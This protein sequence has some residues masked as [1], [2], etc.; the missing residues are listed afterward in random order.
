MYIFQFFKR[1]VRKANIPTWIYLILNILIIGAMVQLFFGD[2]ND[3][4]FYQSL[5]IGFLIY[6]L[7]IGISIS[8]LGEWV[9]RCQYGCK[10]IRETDNLSEVLAIFTEVYEKARKEDP[11]LCK[12]I[13]LYISE[14]NSPNAFALGRRTVCIT[15]GLLNLPINEIRAVLGHEFGHLA[16]KDTD[17]LLVISVGNLI[18]SGCMVLI[19][20]TIQ[21]FH[22][23]IE[24]IALVMGRTGGALLSLFNYLYHLALSVFVHGFTM[25]WSYLGILLVMKSSRENEYEADAYSVQLG[26]GVSLYN[27]LK[28]YGDGRAEGVF[29]ALSRSHPDK[30]LRMDR[31]KEKLE[32]KDEENL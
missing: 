11:D 29:A 9:N 19:N 13:K 27:F 31:I 6:V 32:R 30:Y 20:L 4:Q 18:I 17:L 16:H 1:L 15:K 5:L 10:K 26:Y 3:W 8:R 12:D 7:S 21:I 23:F 22:L 28:E 2:G 24:L 25:L 14:E